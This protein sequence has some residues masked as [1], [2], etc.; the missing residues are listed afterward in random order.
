MRIIKNKIF[1]LKF[2]KKKLH[3]G[4]TKKRWYSFSFYQQMA[5][6]GSEVERVINWKKNP[7]KI[8]FM[9]LII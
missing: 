8:I 3:K 6:V 2:G 1:Q 9:L 4:L 5:N 7:L